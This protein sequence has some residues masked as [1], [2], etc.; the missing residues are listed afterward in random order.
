M[1]AF[2][3]RVLAPAPPRMAT[4]RPLALARVA[5]EDRS[6]H[7]RDREERMQSLRKLDLTS[8]YMSHAVLEAHT[9]ALQLEQFEFEFEF[10]FEHHRMKGTIT[11]DPNT[12]SLEPWG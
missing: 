8:M 6:W 7:G 11:L 1:T 3:A 10:E 4:E 12:C 9:I 2:R 5:R